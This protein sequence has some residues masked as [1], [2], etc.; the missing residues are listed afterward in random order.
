MS[1]ILIPMYIPTSQNSFF[2]LGIYIYLSSVL[3]GKLIDQ[4]G[5]GMIILL[6][7]HFLSITIY[8]SK[9]LTGELK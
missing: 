6:I 1:N 2:A 9:Y 3:I 7:A 8:I 4:A 5:H